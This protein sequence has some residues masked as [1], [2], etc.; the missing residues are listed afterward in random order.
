MAE[1]TTQDTGQIRLTAVYKHIHLAPEENT[2]GHARM[3]LH[4]GAA[5]PGAVGGRLWNMKRIECLLALARGCEWGCRELN[6]TAQ[7]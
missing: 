5:G 3:R 2:A 1:P 4:S 6:P 7:G